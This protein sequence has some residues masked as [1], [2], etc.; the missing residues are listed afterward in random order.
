M[1]FWTSNPYI[2]VRI[3]IDLNCRI[4]IRIGTNAD[5]QHCLNFLCG[6]EWGVLSSG[7]G[8]IV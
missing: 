3:H 5:Q 7:S 8:G 6:S 1:Y 4:R 2:H